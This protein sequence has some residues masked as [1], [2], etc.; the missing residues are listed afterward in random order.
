MAL[1]L[2]K[3]CVGCDSLDELRGWQEE[4]LEGKRRRGEAPEHVHVTRVAPKRTAELL[5]GGSL[6]WV[7]KG[8]IQARQPLLDLR[9]Q[10][11]D[12][13]I[14]RCAI[15][16]APELIPVR[17]QPRRPFQGWRY[18]PGADAPPDLADDAQAAPGLPQA[19]AQEL[20]ALGLL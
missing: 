18:L 8:A 3:L 6:Y 17:P 1:H 5:D 13:G 9:V 20:R 11:G 14:E 4:R 12:D 7:I 19:L 10:R 2:Q 16:L 15:I